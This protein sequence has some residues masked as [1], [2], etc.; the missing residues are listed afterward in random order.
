MMHLSIKNSTIDGFVATSMPEIY[1][2]FYSK[3]VG[4]FLTK[5]APFDIGLELKNAVVRV[6][7]TET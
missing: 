6:Q 1:K 7:K 2:Q 4:L 5:R 3:L